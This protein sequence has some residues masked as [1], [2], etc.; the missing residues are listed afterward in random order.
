MRHPIRR[1]ATTRGRIAR[2]ARLI[3][4]RAEPTTAS[5]WVVSTTPTARTRTAAPAGTRRTARARRICDG[6][7]SSRPRAWTNARPTPVMTAAMPRPNAATRITPHAGRPAAIVASRISSA[8]ADGTRPPAS[9]STNRLRQRDR[10]SGRR[11][12]AVADA[13]VRVLEAVVVGVVV[14]VV[15]RAGVSCACSWSWSCRGRAH[16]GARS[17]RRAA[18]SASDLGQQHP[19]A[20]QHDRHRRDQRRDADHEVGRQRRLRRE[21]HR[22]QPQDPERVRHAHGHPEADRVARRPAR[23]DEV[24]GHQRL[25]VPRGQRMPAPSIAAVNRAIS[26]ISG[27]AGAVAQ[28]VG[29][30]RLAAR[31]WRHRPTRAG[32]AGAESRVGRDGGRRRDGRPAVDVTADRRRV[33]DVEA[34]SAGPPGDA[35]ND[36]PAR[37]ARR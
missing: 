8:L 35:A 10:R 12:V 33:R 9:P 24:R 14:V 29:D 19:A 32:A 20:D 17:A 31:A 7:R 2:P 13:A 5:A 6:A 30:R 1:R 28:D 34:G 4:G 11:H 21:H 3:R 37:R 15:V 23:A 27:V 36:T 26:P 16:G 25:A 22:R 18:N